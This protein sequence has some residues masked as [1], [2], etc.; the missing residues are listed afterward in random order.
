MPSGYVVY[1]LKET[2]MDLGK[3]E[4]KVVLDPKQYVDATNSD[5]SLIDSDG[6]P[7]KYEIRKWGRKMHC[8]FEVTEETADGVSAA[9][10]VLKNIEGKEQRSRFTF[11][12]C[13]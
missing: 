4:F 12:I 13:K 7:I 8:V 3:H 5:I 1:G 6:K 9:D 11:W 10:L 2:Y